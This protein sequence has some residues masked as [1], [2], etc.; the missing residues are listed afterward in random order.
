[1]TP[2]DIFR[3][4]LLREKEVTL[5]VADKEAAQYLLKLLRTARQRNSAAMYDLGLEDADPLR[6]KTVLLDLQEADGICRARFYTGSTKR[7]SKV[8]FKLLGPEDL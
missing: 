5:E 7:T 1:M 4:Y 6:D 8:L 3:D 2:T